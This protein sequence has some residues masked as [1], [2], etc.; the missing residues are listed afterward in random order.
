MNNT[1]FEIAK[2]N[3]VGKLVIGDQVIPIK[4][5]N[6]EDKRSTAYGNWD[7]KIEAIV[8]DPSSKLDPNDISTWY[9]RTMIANAEGAISYSE[10]AKREVAKYI[11]RE[12]AKKEVTNRK[13]GPYPWGQ[14]IPEIK[15]VIFNN[16]ATIVIWKD[17]EKTVVKAQNGEA[18]DPEKGL[19]MAITKRA[20][21]NKGNY[22]NVLHHHLL[23]GQEQYTPEQFNSEV[24]N[25]NKYEELWE[26]FR[27]EVGRSNNALAILNSVVH[28]KKATKEQILNA[29]KDA[30]KALGRPENES[31]N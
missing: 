20:L 25:L 6:I 23:K 10:Y 8:V 11:K 18:Y 14:S 15:E 30:V 4:V 22:C 31:D 19:V 2:T 16:P 26:K 1:I 21:G 7:T 5:T 28:Y 17:G 3:G 12:A 29:V 24:C 13:S 9:P 27:D